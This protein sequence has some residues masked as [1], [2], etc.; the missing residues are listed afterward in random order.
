MG[1]FLITK[2]CRC[3]VRYFSTRAFLPASSGVE[4]PLD[5]LPE[6]PELMIPNANQ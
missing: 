1:P 2:M 4:R 6:L 5:H 3:S